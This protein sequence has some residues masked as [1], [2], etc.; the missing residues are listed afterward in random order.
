MDHPVTAETL[1]RDEIM[2]LTDELEKTSVALEN[3]HTEIAALSAQREVL[4]RTVRMHDG[5]EDAEELRHSLEESSLLAEELE[6]ANAALMALNEALDERVAERTAA[7]DQANAHLERL[8]ADLHRRVEAEAA[9]RA[10]AQTELFQMQKL[11][12]I[13]QLTGGIA[14][15]FNNLLTVIINGLQLLSQ[16]NEPGRCERVLRRTEEAAWRGADLTRRLLAF[17]RRQAL[18]PTRLELSRH[19]EGVRDLLCHGLREDIEVRTDVGCDIWPLEADVAALELALLN[20]AVNARDAMPK[21]GTLIL[22]ARNRPL[23][24]GEAQRLGLAAGDYVEIGVADTGIGMSP[25]LLDKVFEPFFTTKTDGKGTGLGL[26]QVY[27]FAKQSDGAAW[28]ESRHGLGTTVR[29]LLPRSWRAAPPH[30]PDQP[31]Q[32]VRARRN[33]RLT[34][35]VVEDDD[36][37]A[38]IVLEMLTQIGH[39]GTRVRTVASAL[40][41]LTGAEQVDMVFSDVLLPGG[42]SGLDLAREIARRHLGIPVILTS[43][44]GGGMTQRLAAASLPFVRKPYRIETLRQTIDDTLHSYESSPS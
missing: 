21:G 32:T 31:V 11:E 24:E 34:V 12:A 41:V 10:K 9:A 42:D 39:S 4:L 22:S 15:D 23:P 38:A 27:G 7:L 16:A 26:P 19:I 2:R 33:E 18:H 43:G 30:E 25:E 13:G 35:L 40:A 8:N 1:L 36:D 29:M 5:D 17:A 28:V 20:L 14:H 44:Y 37:V 3:A 6:E